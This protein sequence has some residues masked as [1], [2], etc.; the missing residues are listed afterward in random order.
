[1]NVA[2]SSS[3]GTA[4]PP[5]EPG[6]PDTRTGS[7]ALDAV[8]R[9][10]ELG[11]VVT[12]VLL[13]GA[14]TVSN[15]NFLSQQ[16][17]RDILLA[18]AIT[19]LLA[20]GMTLV[21]V[22]RGIDLSVG[23]VLGLS[24]FGTATLL[25]EHPGLPVPVAL[26]V[27]VAIGAACGAVN[28]VVIAYG[29]VPALVATLGTLYVFRGVV[30]FW[31]G[32]SRISAGDMPRGFLDFGTARILGVPYLFLIGLAVLV[33]VGQFLRRYRTGRDLYAIGSSGEAA[34]LAGIGINS[35]LMLAYVA[36]GALAGLGGVLYAARY[37]TVDASAGT[38]MELNIVAAVVVGGVAIF[39]GSG[40]VYGA[41][42]GALLLTVINNA[43][44]VLGIDQFWQRAIVGVLI[45]AAIALDRLV[46]LRV[47]ESLRK[48]DSHVR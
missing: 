31:A 25:R 12:L 33:V 44:P 20:C 9:F 8:L 45:I 23:S 1:M 22:S 27:G 21:V 10:R 32:G 37:G 36:S 6:E 14:T 2:A 17:I 3:S 43:L 11:L 29:K 34:R 28:G 16:S 38:G 42:L 19:L 41:A 39:G 26:L 47:A 30:Y 24:A 48:K 46:A 5:G 35:R 40:S 7:A 15:A 18:T 13:V 4:P